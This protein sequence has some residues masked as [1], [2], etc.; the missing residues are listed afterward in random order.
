MLNK[1]HYQG[2]LLLLFHR[3]SSLRFPSSRQR[4]DRG[5]TEVTAKKQHSYG[6]YAR[7]RE[8]KKKEG[9]EKKEINE[10]EE[11]KENKRTMGFVFLRRA[12]LTFK[13]FL[14]QNK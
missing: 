10:R 3:F 2:R 1:S 9:E 5:V 14:P 8:E 12:P 13:L 4:C 6:I 7:A 11:K